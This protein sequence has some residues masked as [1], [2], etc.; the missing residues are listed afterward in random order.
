MR[1]AKNCSG[2]GPGALAGT[3]LVE[4]PSFGEVPGRGDQILPGGARSVNGTAA[5]SG[6]H[7]FSP[8]IAEG[9][10]VGHRELG[11]HTRMGMSSRAPTST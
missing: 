1:P 5:Q 2:V 11:V 9:L 10:N 4:D 6:Q 3:W 8:S 7:L